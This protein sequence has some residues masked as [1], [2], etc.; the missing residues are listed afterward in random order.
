MPG[1]GEHV[2]G[3]AGPVGQG[4]AGLRPA[5]SILAVAG[6]VWWGV[7]A[8]AVTGGTSGSL[9]WVWVLAGVAL[10]A[11]FLLLARRRLGSEGAQALMVANNRLY[12][13]VN[14]AQVVGIV[15]VVSLAGRAGVPQWIPV[16]VTAVF[17]VHF[18][19]FAR[20]FRWRGYAWLALAL[21]AVAALGA[22]LAASGRDGMQVHAVVGPAVAVV[23]WAGVVGAVRSRPAR[24]PAT[25]DRVPTG[26]AAPRP[27]RGSLGA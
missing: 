15:A 13:A 4:P 20:A 7:A 19:P 24:A 14:V 22:A 5:G 9:G 8:G 27:D 1:P 25:G 18:L 12:G 2:D 3:A 26:P 17:A 10:G 16:G 21:L 6:A 11:G 23:L